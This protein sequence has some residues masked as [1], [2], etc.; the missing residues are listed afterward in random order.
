MYAGVPMCPRRSFPR[1]RCIAACCQ[2]QCLGNAEVCHSRRTASAENV[3]R[4][5]IAMHDIVRMSG[6][7]CT[8]NITQDRERFIQWNRTA[9]QTLAK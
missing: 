7:E 4:L 8:R 5:D 2:A 3:F 1:A 6:C 9:P